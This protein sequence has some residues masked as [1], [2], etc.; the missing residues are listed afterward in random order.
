MRITNRIQLLALLALLPVGAAAQ[1]TSSPSWVGKRVAIAKTERAMAPACPTRAKVDHYSREQSLKWDNASIGC[2]LM[3]SGN[4]K[5]ADV[6]ADSSDYLQVKFTRNSR[7][8][9]RTLWV[10]RSSM[11]LV[12]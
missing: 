6:V 8:L 3:R 10:P 2:M 9:S 1:D 4:F 12:P 11:A 5:R 7:L